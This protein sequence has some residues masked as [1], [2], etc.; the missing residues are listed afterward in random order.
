MI[1]NDYLSISYDDYFENSY[2]KLIRP[3]IV[4]VCDCLN[5]ESNT[6]KH[7]TLVN[8]GFCLLCEHATFNMDISRGVGSYRFISDDEL[9]KLLT[10][11]KVEKSSIEK[12]REN[13]SKGKKG[14]SDK[15]LREW[16]LSAITELDFN[17]EKCV[18][19]LGFSSVQAMYTKLNSLGIE[20]KALY[21]KRYNLNK[22]QELVSYKDICKEKSPTKQ[23]RELAN[24]RV[25]DRDE[26]YKAILKENKYD[27]D[28]CIK[29]FN[30]NDKKAL[31][32]FLNNKKIS[33]NEEMKKFKE[34]IC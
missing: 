25:S 1:D 11:S 17:K 18:T 9:N 31:T 5:N 20:F 6:S 32:A 22:K 26:L 29:A 2:G 30:V 8:E 34:K 4:E 27:I 13:K 28:A 10:K 7:T 3:T 16:V 33:F 24:R 23:L 21:G 15:E 14:P 19:E 12:F